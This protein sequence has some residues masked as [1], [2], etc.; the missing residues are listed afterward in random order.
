MLRYIVIRSTI[1][2]L[3]IFI[4]NTFYVGT[5]VLHHSTLLQRFFLLL[6]TQHIETKCFQLYLYLCICITCQKELEGFCVWNEKTNEAIEIQF[7]IDLLL[8]NFMMFV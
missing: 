4:S 1:E 2:L 6:P 5:Q 3:I 7:T 8:S